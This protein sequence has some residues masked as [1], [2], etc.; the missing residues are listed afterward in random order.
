MIEIFNNIWNTLTTENELIVNIMF[1]PLSFVE[2]FVDMIL[3]CSIL[4]RL[5]NAPSPSAP[6]LKTAVE[7]ING[8]CAVHPVQRINLCAALYHA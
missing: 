5:Q 6:L 2:A 3:F 7:P 1:I 8:M 4:Y